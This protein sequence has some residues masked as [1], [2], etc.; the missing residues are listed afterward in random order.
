MCVPNPLVLEDGRTLVAFNLA[1]VRALA[2]IALLMAALA[3]WLV[4][5][6]ALLPTAGR[7][8]GRRRA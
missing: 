3:V 5:N 7:A 8:N 4:R 1:D 2:G 6:R